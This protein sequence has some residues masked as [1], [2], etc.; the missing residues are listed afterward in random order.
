MMKKLA[1]G[2]AA[3]GALTVS[4][5][6]QAAVIY[7]NGA[8]DLISGSEM[9]AYLQSEDFTL[10]AATTITGIHFWS[11]DSGLADGTISWQIYSDNLGDPGSILASGNTAVTRTATGNALFFGTEYANDFGIA[12]L[13]LGPGTYHLGLHNGALS[14]TNRLEFYWET[15]ALNGTTTGR[16][17]AAPFTNAWYDNG[18][19]HAFYLTS[20]QT[21][22]EPASLALLGI[23]FAGLAAARRRPA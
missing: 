15:T 17:D 2:L 1:R 20:D 18:Q 11:I 12:A 21:V 23:G 9:T 16:E 4:C 7:D 22:P 6:V 5:A 10:G 13:S 8:P 3:A 14:V 19:E